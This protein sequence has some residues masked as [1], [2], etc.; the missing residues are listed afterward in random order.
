MRRKNI[1]A[2][3]VLIFI[4]LWYGYL[5]SELPVRTL[6]NTPDPS[7]FPWINTIILLLLSVSLL[8][9]G[10]F[11]T[12]E[13]E[14]KID[15]VA[16]RLVITSLALF[17]GY[18]LILPP[19]GFVVAS[20]PFFAAMM[21]LFEERRPIWVASSSIAVTVVLFSVFRYGFG[22]LLPLGVMDGLVP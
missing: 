4:S 8:V 21:V 5:T 16:R 9:Q 2:G 10:L 22:V 12:E 3:V 15:P 7:F 13:G 14:S 19:L 1:I 18:L 17:F 6:P 20:I 11:F